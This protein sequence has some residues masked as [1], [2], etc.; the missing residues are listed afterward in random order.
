MMG[1]RLLKW[2]FCDYSG[3]VTMFEKI[4]GPQPWHFDTNNCGPTLLACGKIEQIGNQTGG[5]ARRP[6]QRTTVHRRG[7]A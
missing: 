7:L 2:R 5:V 1:F 4:K 3:P 6:L